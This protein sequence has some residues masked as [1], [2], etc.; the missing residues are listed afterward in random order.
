MPTTEIEALFSVADIGVFPC[1]KCCRPMK[2][3]CIEL[4][5][6][7]FDVRTFQCERCNHTETFAVS[8]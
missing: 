6:P 3:S 2:L 7:G 4:T 5:A 1:A 8:I